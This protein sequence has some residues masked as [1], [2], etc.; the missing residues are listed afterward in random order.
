MAFAR[1]CS[2]C[3]A[4]VA[5]ADAKFCVI[6]GGPLPTDCPNCGAANPADSRYCRVC[7]TGLMAGISSPAP[8]PAAVSCPR[9]RASNDVN[10]LFCYACGLPLDEPD[11]RRAGQLVAGG[12]AAGFWIRLLAWFIDFIILTAAELILAALSPYDTGLWTWQDTILLLIALLIPPAYTTIGV[13]VFSTTVGKRVLG[14]YV[15]RSDGSRAG[16]LRALARYL[17]YIPSALLLGIGFLMIGFSGDKRGLHDHI[18]DT[19]VIKR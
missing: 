17:A 5:A 9:C 19:V 15:R 10:D 18:C 3:G 4:P 1:I 14:L 16:P 2:G 13:S 6:C 12:V 11:R 7:G 8:Q